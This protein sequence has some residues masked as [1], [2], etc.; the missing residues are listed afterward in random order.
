MEWALCLK[1]MGCLLPIAEARAHGGTAW[2]IF[3][4]ICLSILSVCSLGQSWTDMVHFGREGKIWSSH[5]QRQL[6]TWSIVC[7]SFT[8]INANRMV[9]NHGTF[10]TNFWHKDFVHWSSPGSIEIYSLLSEYLWST[11]RSVNSLRY[12][13]LFS[14][15]LQLPGYTIRSYL[16]E[17]LSLTGVTSEGWEFLS[18][19]Q[20]PYQYVDVRAGVPV[21]WPH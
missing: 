7:S 4:V 20:S 13:V 17:Y 5:S 19:S 2:D 15:V 16:R 1:S 6:V 3:S 12:W 10:C 11:F 21:A 8:D 18:S 9:Y 14:I